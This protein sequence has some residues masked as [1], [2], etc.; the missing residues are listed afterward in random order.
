M[1][2]RVKCIAAV[3]WWQLVLIIYWVVIN[4]APT[5]EITTILPWICVKDV[6]TDITAFVLLCP[7]TGRFRFN[8]DDARVL[9]VDSDGTP[10]DDA[11]SVSSSDTRRRTP[12]RLLP[13]HS[14]LN[15]QPADGNYA[16]SSPSDSEGKSLGPSIAIL[17]VTI[18]YFI[19]V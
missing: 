18:V 11:S 17:L 3:K 13:R 19:Q 1:C 7:L 10:T 9:G 6:G 12:T 2:H 8:D 15:P 4:L 5:W 14:S 16:T